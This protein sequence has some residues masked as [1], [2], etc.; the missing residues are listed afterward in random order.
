MMKARVLM[1]QTLCKCASTRTCFLAASVVP[2]D[3][4]R[5]HVGSRALVPVDEN[6]LHALVATF[7]FDVVRCFCLDLS[8]SRRYEPAIRVGPKDPVH[9]QASVKYTPCQHVSLFELGRR[10]THTIHCDAIESLTY[11]RC[12]T[13]RLQSHRALPLSNFGPFASFNLHVSP[14]NTLILASYFILN[15]VDS[16]LPCACSFEVKRMES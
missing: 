10:P 14:W 3:R 7:E 12:C 6:R 5:L 13:F 11:M 16:P 8:I 9:V 2:Q 15:K 4:R 1:V